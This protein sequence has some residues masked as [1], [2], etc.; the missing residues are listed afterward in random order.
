MQNSKGKEHVLWLALC[1]IQYFRD[2]T[3][4]V[5]I[6]S[7]PS[8]RVGVV[9]SKLIAKFCER[10]VTLRSMALIAIEYMLDITNQVTSGGNPASFLWWTPRAWES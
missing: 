3:S 9:F 1:V 5:K 7:R 4:E 10:D 8:L 6:N 2:K